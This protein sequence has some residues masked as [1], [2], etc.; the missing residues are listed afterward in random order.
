MIGSFTNFT[1]STRTCGT[2]KLNLDF[3]P[4][5]IALEYIFENHG[6]TEMVEKD[7]KA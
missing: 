4:H 5:R 1:S 7:R 3:H 6:G 2:I